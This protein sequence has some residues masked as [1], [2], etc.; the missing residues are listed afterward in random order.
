MQ[1]PYEA[2]MM[3]QMG[4]APGCPAL[5]G[6]MMPGLGGGKPVA[7]EGRQS[8]KALTVWRNQKIS[9]TLWLCKNSY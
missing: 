2:M 9:D 3:A 1:N 5:P 8:F 4:M 6:L 7:W